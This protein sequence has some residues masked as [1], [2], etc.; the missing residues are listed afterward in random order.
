MRLLHAVKVP[1]EETAA[2]SEVRWQ[3]MKQF[4]N[5]HRTELALDDWEESNID[6]VISAVVCLPSILV[7]AESIS[8]AMA[9]EE[10]SLDTN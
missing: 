1:A 6:F 10:Q 3:Q 8:Q 4:I 5:R 9:E 7:F 2:Q